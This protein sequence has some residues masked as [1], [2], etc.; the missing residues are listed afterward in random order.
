MVTPDIAMSVISSA[1]TDISDAV[2]MLTK[3]TGSDS[4]DGRSAMSDDR[5]REDVKFRMNQKP[6]AREPVIELLEL[7][8]DYVKFVLKDTDMSVANALRRVMIAEVPT[9]AI[10]MVE[11]ESNSTVL[12]DEY[13]AHRLGMIP[14][15][16]H[17]ASMFKENRDCDCTSHCSKCSVVFRI[18]VSNT[19]DEKLLVTSKHLKLE[20][21]ADDMAEVQPV[22]H[23]GGEVLL[24][25]SAV[26][27]VKLGK[28]QEL[29]ARCIAKKGVGKEHAK[30]I[31]AAVATYQ[32]DPEIVI[33]DNVMEDLTEQQKEDF[34][35]SCPCNVYSFNKQTQTVR[36]ENAIECTFCDECVYKAEDMGVED[37]VEITYKKDKFIFTVESV[38]SL[39][40]EEIVL[41]AMSVL[42]SK[43]NMLK[44]EIEQN[45]QDEY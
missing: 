39:R 20:Q 16:S 26:L 12:A 40:P 11:I 7:K 19:G 10:D 5:P 36:V 31:P 33:D 18:N 14:L 21:P 45:A 24:T 34:V 9:I 4:D 25:D 17:N 35:N 27:V 2:S 22:H 44:N 30:W 6:P 23:T 13:I 1:Y 15:T 41:N 29:N 3:E 32:L 42:K 8:E 37:L 43:M 28:N 38:G